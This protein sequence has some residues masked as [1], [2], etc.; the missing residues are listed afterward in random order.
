MSYTRHRSSIKSG[1]LLAWSSQGDW[2]SRHGLET[3]LTRIGT[4]SEWTH[5]G[6]AWVEH[7]RVWVIELTT[8]GCAPRLL[9]DEL[10]CAWLPAPRRL[11]DRALTYAFSR[12]GRLRYSRWQAVLGW[13]KRLTIGDD[14]AGQCSELVIEILRVDAMAPTDVA[15]PAALIDGALRVWGSRLAWL[16][17]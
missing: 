9:S 2:R 16:A 15:T 5:V 8:L 4:E 6:I 17:H 13:L 10:P 1:D 12:F 7:G 3:H 11:S 14:L